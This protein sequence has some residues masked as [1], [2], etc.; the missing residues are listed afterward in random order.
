M[1]SSLSPNQLIIPFANSQY[2]PPCLDNVY[3]KGGL[4]SYFNV[5]LYETVD[6]DDASYAQCEKRCRRQWGKLLL[7][8]G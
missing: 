5:L 2:L 7:I 8:V 4:S 3:S 1:I 6:V